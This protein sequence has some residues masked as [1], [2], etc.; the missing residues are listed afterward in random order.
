[1]KQCVFLIFLILINA[2]GLA[3]SAF[4]TDTLNFQSYVPAGWKLLS[5]TIGDLDS[6]GKDDAVLVLEKDDPANR[7]QNSDLE[8]NELNLNPRRLLVLFQKEDGYQPVLSTDKL[9]PPE[10]NE[11]STCLEDPLGEIKILKGVLK[12]TLSYWSS[13]GSWFTSSD[14][15]LFRYAE[16]ARFHLIGRNHDEFHRGSGEGMKYSINYLTGK[17]K[18]TQGLNEFKKSKPKTEWKSIKNNKPRYLDEISS[19]SLLED[20]NLEN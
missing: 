17:I 2:I 12:I 3:P 10:S 13:C 4:A 16:N 15:Y 7:K 9:L 19:F 6:D 8:P 14:E 11:D 1:M 5:S 20:S 18:I